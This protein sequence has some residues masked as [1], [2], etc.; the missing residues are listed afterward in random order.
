MVVIR[1]YHFVFILLASLLLA[2]CASSASTKKPEVFASVYVI[3]KGWHTA[4]ILN[5]DDLSG[6]A[7]PERGDFPTARFFEIG[8]GDEAFYQAKDPTIAQALRAGLWPTPSVLHVSGSTDNP[9]LLYSKDNREEVPLDADGFKALVTFI[10]QS[11][12]RDD[13][14][15]A[16]AAGPGKNSS[17]RFYP[18]KGNF[19]ILYTCN[20]WVARALK[21][22][23]LDIDV[24][25]SKI[26]KSLMVQ[27][28]H[29]R[30]ARQ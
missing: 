18:S 6:D 20:T 8:W 24:G 22:G 26:A 16:L 15:Q 21:D 4:I 1:T 19:H 17:S 7:I 11:F 23:G 10:D 5:R 2:A 14:A 12:E 13:G 9:F 28:R 27:I 25:T 30:W 29:S 3:S